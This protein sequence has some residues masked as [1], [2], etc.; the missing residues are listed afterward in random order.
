M[1][2]ARWLEKYTGFVWRSEVCL[3][4]RAHWENLANVLLT[5]KD[6]FRKTVDKRQGFLTT[7]PQKA[8]MQSLLTTLQ[9][10]SDFQK[11]LAAI[12]HCPPTHYSTAQWET[13]SILTELL[14]LLA[15]ELSL[16]FHE[17]KQID[18]IALN[19]AAQQALGSP[20]APTDFALALD[21]QIKHFL[22]DEFQDTSLTHFHLI[23]KLI[24]GWQP[25]D[26]RT[27]FIVGDPMQSIYRFRNAEVGL[28][29]RTQQQGIGAMTLN[30][31]QLSTNF[32][33]DPRL[34]SWFN[35][36]FPAIFPRV[37]DIPTGCVPYTPVTTPTAVIDHHDQ[38]ITVCQE[39]QHEA[40]HLLKT[41]Q[42]LREH[43]PQATQAI[44]VRSRTQQIRTAHI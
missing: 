5:E 34:V 38:V 18:F 15:A 26:G 44:L 31:L 3:A 29:L 40:M 36:C 10:H 17:K 16:V 9:E 2:E 20:D 41:V 30:A 21:Y 23:E 25:D 37:M 28:F 19:L 32:R 1:Q 33:S 11:A 39:A 12:R 13:L 24:A 27:L 8:A 6:A 42:Q 43:A 7:D 14:P 22:I 35:A 4:D